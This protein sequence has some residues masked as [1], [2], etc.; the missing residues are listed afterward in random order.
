M[1]RPDF[2]FRDKKGAGNTDVTDAPD[3]MVGC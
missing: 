1:I 3:D 2:L